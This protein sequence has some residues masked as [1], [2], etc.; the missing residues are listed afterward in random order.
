[1]RALRPDFAGVLTV[2]VPTGVRESVR[3]GC[4]VHLPVRWSDGKTWL[5]RIK[6]HCVVAFG[7][8]APEVR[9]LTLESER[10]TM[11]A[12]RAMGLAVPEVHSLVVGA[13]SRSPLRPLPVSWPALTWTAQ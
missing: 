11:V 6:L 5:I 9:R 2:D 1:M 4:N 3:G 13:S 12:L 8:I 7:M 10:E